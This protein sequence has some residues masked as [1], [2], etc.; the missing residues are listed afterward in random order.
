MDVMEDKTLQV[1]NESM[2]WYLADVQGVYAR[3]YMIQ[4][5]G[6]EIYFQDFSPEVY[7]IFNSPGENVVHC[8]VSFRLNSSLFI[9]TIS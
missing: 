3:R 4:P 5:C 2:H 9:I 6:I 8:I 1:L 7:F